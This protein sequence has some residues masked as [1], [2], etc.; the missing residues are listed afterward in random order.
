MKPKPFSSL[1]HFTVPVAMCSLPGD[2]VLRNA[3]GAQ[4]NNYERWHSVAEHNA[5]HKHPVYPFPETARERLAR[6]RTASSS[7]TAAQWG[8]GPGDRMTE[9]SDPR[10]GLRDP[11][12]ATGVEL[13]VVVPFPTRPKPFESQQSTPPVASIA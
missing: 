1:N 4:G 11:M 5:Q 8:R 9:C 6:T 3:G 2:R 7:P 13:S 10:R 12:T